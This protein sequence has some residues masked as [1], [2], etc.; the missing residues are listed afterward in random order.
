VGEAC[1]TYGGGEAYTEFWWGILRE[2]DHL[3]ETGVDGK[4][5]TWIIRK[6]DV[7]AW[8]GL[9]WHRIGTDSGHL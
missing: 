7:V 1:S 8:S 4:L 9:I 3:G 2:R 6:W 5:I